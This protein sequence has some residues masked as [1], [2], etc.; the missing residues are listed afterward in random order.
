MNKPSN[1]KMWAESHNSVYCII[2]RSST[3]WWRFRGFT[4]WCSERVIFTSFS[5]SVFIKKGKQFF[6]CIHLLIVSW[7]IE[8]LVNVWENSKKGQNFMLA[9]MYH[10][11]T[12]QSIYGYIWIRQYRNVLCMWATIKFLPE[13]AVHGNTAFL[14]LKPATREIF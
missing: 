10:I 5:R 2:T 14:D 6:Q 11:W 1:R 7:V 8:T 13:K 12:R 9:Y 3:R 4:L